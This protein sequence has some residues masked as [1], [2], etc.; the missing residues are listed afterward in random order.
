[1]RDT[2]KYFSLLCVI[3][4]VAIFYPQKA[5]A[6]WSLVLEETFQDPKSFQ[7]NWIFEEGFK[8]NEELQYYVSGLGNNAA[9]S[10]EGL[11]ITA[12]KQAYMNPKYDSDSK[13]WRKARAFGEYTSASIKLK[14]YSI[15]NGKVEVVV[16]TPEGAGL[17]PAIWLA[18]KNKDCLQ[19]VFL[20]KH[21]GCYAEIDMMEIRG[22]EPD[23]VHVSVH[24]GPD[25]KSRKVRKTK[26]SFSGLSNREVTYT[27]EL[28]PDTIFV[29]VDDEEILVQDRNALDWSGTLRPLQQPYR[30]ILNL[31]LGGWAKTLNENALPAQFQIKSVRI[32]DW[33]PEENTEE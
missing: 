31:A 32:W 21:R 26:K 16:M 17:W 14:N 4:I 24:T 19:E 30:L 5:F 8:R 22:Q 15:F 9:L 2:I 7:E 29:S 3:S 13:D 28:T 12:R 18:G 33:A 11:V 25:A 1:M 23:V 20:E 10:P 6:G 27:A